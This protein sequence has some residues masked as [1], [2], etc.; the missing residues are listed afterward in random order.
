MKIKIDSVTNGYI[1]NVEGYN[2]NDLDIDIN[3]LKGKYT[4]VETSQENLKEEIGKLIMRF[5]DA[6]DYYS[7]GPSS[8]TI[9]IKESD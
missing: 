5:M 6:V 8:I 9:N 7:D 3:E 2:D 4:L 1:V